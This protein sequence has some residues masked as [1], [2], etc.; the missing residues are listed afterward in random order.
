MLKPK[1]DQKGLFKPSCTGLLTAVF[2]SLQRT[3]VDSVL[4]KAEHC[5]AFLSNTN[6]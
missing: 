2:S 6:S 5:R 4:V 3:W 1:T